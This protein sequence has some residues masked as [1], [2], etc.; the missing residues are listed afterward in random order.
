MELPG[1]VVDMETEDESINVL[2]FGESGAGKT[3]FA[4]SASNGLMIATEKGVISAQRRGSK[5]KLWKANTWSEVLKAKQWLEDVYEEEGEIP[6]DWVSVD[7]G[8]MMQTLNLRGILKEEFDKTPSKRDLD[9]PQIQDHQKWQNE[10]KRTMQEFVDLPVNLCVTALP[11]HI[12]TENDEGE[13]EEWILPQFLGGKG[14]IAWA[15]VGMF[16][17]GGRVQ[18]KKV[19]KD[20]KVRT[21]QRI[22]WSKNGN[23]WGRDRYDALGSYT[24]NLTL[25]ELSRRV[26]ESGAKAAP[27]DSNAKNTEEPTQR[28]RRTAATK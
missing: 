25:D 6:F 28:R 13:S 2:V 22:Y 10:F 21:F 11:L 7:S 18:L 9:I 27:V 16:G 3:P 24:D 12:E 1:N 17:A 20:D 15:I 8:T 19:K 23:H 26:R 5:M 4:G 14:A